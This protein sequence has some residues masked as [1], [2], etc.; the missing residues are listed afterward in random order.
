MPYLTKRAGRYL[1]QVTVGGRRVAKTFGTKIEALRWRAETKIEL[2]RRGK[3][4]PQKTLGEACEKYRRDVAPTH[5]GERWECIR[6]IAFERES[7]KHHLLTNLRPEDFEYWIQRRLA[8]G[9]KGATVNRELNLIS[10]VLAHAVRWKWLTLNPLTK[11]HRPPHSPPRDRR[12]SEEENGRIL[13]ALTYEEEARVR[14][15]RQEL[16]VGFL[17]AIET[18]MR[19]GELWDLKWENVHLSRNFVALPETKNGTR[20]EVPLSS[21]AVELLEK[22]KPSQG[23]AETVMKYNQRSSGVIFRRALQLAG[24]QGMTFHDTRHEA[25]SR[26]ARKLDVLDLARMMGHRDPRSL[27][28]YYNATASEIA[29]RL[30]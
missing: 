19:Q 24:I 13:Q 4:V 17:L 12:I 9:V 10:S 27:M 2:G 8:T 18:A 25:I 7:L 29:E 15:Q 26:L 23:N 1:A 11:I 16:A 20:R 5:K 6:L 3:I 30:G 28:V 22:L 14:T 21:R